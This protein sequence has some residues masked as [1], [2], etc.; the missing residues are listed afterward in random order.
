MAK[1]ETTD[2]ATAFAIGAALGIGA[3]LLLR[4]GRESETERIVR[5]LKPLRKRMRKQLNRAGRGASGGA[6]AAEQAS[7]KLV[8]TGRSVLGDFRDQV[9]RIVQSARG[10][11]VDTAREAVK[12]AGDAA[13]EDV[14]E[15][16]RSTF[17]R[18]R[19]AAR[20]RMRR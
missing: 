4:S 5:E 16:A 8:E 2:L 15:N 14:Y 1:Q 11:I 17:G 18:A 9:T 10:E 6:R 12:R 20:K 3:T 19:K 7:E 13:R